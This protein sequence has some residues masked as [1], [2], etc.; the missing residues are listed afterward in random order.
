MRPEHKAKQAIHEFVSDWKV[1]LDNDHHI[2]DVGVFYELHHRQYGYPDPSAKYCFVNEEFT[3]EIEEFKF[4]D[5]LELAGNCFFDFGLGMD[6]AGGMDL[7]MTDGLNKIPISYDG[8]NGMKP[9]RQMF[10][11]P[12]YYRHLNTYYGA[13]EWFD[14]APQYISDFQLE[15]H[16]LSKEKMTKYWT[17]TKRKT[18]Q[19]L[20]NSSHAAVIPM[21]LD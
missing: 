11:Y 20:L 5:T 12:D 8:S 9:P 17:N 3:L 19:A 18:V 7:D 13:W 14:V 10:A 16:G 15:Y 4:A 2:V 6:G 21:F 1:S